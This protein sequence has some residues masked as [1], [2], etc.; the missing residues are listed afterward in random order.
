MRSLITGIAA[1]LLAAPALAAEL[2]RYRVTIDAALERVTVG[3]TPSKQVAMLEASTRGAA[4]R[5]AA[6]SLRNAVLVDDR[7]QLGNDATATYVADLKPSGRRASRSGAE[8]LVLSDPREWLWLPE[9]FAGKDQVRI[10]F[11][12]PLGV[13][14]ATSWKAAGEGGFVLRPQTL[15][16]QGLVAIGKLSTREIALAGATLRLSVASGDAATVGRLGTWAEG[17]W[18]AARSAVAAPPSSIEQLLIVPVDGAREAVP[19]GEVR[20]GGGNS[21]LAIV[22]RNPDPAE[23]R[24][25]WTLYHELSH[26]YLP[27]LGEDRWLS[28]GFASYYQNVLRARAGVLTSEIAWLRLAEG[29][30]RGAAEAKANPGRTVE[31]GKRMVTYWTGAALALEWD[32]ALRKASG[33]KDSL[34]ARLTRFAATHLPATEAWDA[35]RFARSLDQQASKGAAA[36][37]LPQRYFV[38]SMART[39]DARGFPDFLASFKLAGVDPATGRSQPGSPSEILALMRPRP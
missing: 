37:K 10:E 17:V 33:G 9:G 2:A 31:E 23:L 20:R 29:L 34:D 1:L 21:V 19:W 25:D 8:P 22:A 11:V 4:E 32:I 28:E 16:E 7:L 38:D 14:V 30:G 5:I 27:W 35:M 26:L 15:E 39:L 24:E 36:D 3:V 12:L 18:R 13:G 6:G